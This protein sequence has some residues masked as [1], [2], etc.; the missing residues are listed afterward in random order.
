MRVKICGITGHRVIPAEETGGVKKA[1]VREIDRAI[2]DGYTCFLSG[3]ATGADLLFAEIIADKISNQ[4][5]IE[6]KAAIPCQGRLDTLKRSAQT[7]ALLDR[8][9]DIYVV[10]ECYHP[11]AYAKRN[12]F[13]VEQSNRIIAVYDGR[14]TGGTAQTLRLAQRMG[15][16]IR[17]ISIGA[18]EHS[19][20]VCK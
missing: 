19:A 11:G 15:K 12:R 8:C 13:L 9:T 18:T 7:K 4:A 20:S 14:R 3:F 5:A 6:L 2:A 16:D 1:L 10:S 17:E